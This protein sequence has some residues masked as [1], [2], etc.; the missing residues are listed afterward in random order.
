MYRV[1]VFCLFSFYFIGT[2]ARKSRDLIE[3]LRMGH[4]GC[5]FLETL[6]IR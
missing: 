4:M 6:S 1:E 5:Y 3:V 2:L